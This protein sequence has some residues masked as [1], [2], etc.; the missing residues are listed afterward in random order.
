MKTEVV[1]Y[2]SY[3]KS[4]HG[5]MRFRQGILHA[6]TWSKFSQ[7][8]MMCNPNSTVYMSNPGWKEKFKGMP[9][10][11]KCLTILLGQTKP[12]NKTNCEEWCSKTH[13]KCLRCGLIIHKGE[14]ILPLVEGDPMIQ[15]SGA[16]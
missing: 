8:R 4:K 9:N 12:A 11:I 1:F 2:N 6:L 7:Q 3:W 14:T 10:C 16:C 15:H 5:T 13:R